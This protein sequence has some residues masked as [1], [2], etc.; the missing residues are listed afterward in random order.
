MS[1]PLSQEAEDS[2]SE[3]KQEHINKGEI[4]QLPQKAEESLKSLE[5]FLKEHFPAGVP[6][7]KIGLATGG[8]LHQRTEA[9]RDCLKCGISGRFKIG[10]QTIYPVDGVLE[11][12]RKKITVNHLA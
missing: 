3:K 9:N 4:K 2:A 5:A 8:I 11:Y 7:K 12:L 6:R 1:K 10:R